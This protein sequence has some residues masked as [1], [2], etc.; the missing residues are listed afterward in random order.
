M[1]TCGSR[2]EARRLA[3]VVLGEKLAACVNILPG[4][5]S[6]YWWEG[7]LE[8]AP[9]WLLLIKTTAARA[10]QVETA[11]RSVHGYSVPEIIFLPVARGSAP[12]MKWLRAAVAGLALLLI[13]AAQADPLDD[14]I[15]LLGH[16]NEEVR[17]SAAERLTQIGGE[18]VEKQFRTMVASSNPESRQVGVVGL[19]QVSDSDEDLERVRALLQDES[20][21]VRWSAA[22][23]LGRSGYRQAADWLGGVAT[24]DTAESVREVAGEGAERLRTGIQW[25]RALD[26]ALRE[27]KTLSKP[28]LAY[29]FVPGSDYCVRME[30][31]VLRDKEIVN[32]A[33]EFVCARFSAVRQP[34][35]ARKFDVRGAPTLLVLDATGNEMTRIAGLV[36]APRLL[37]RLADARRGKLTL[38]DARRQAGRDP[39]DVAANWLVAESYLEDGREDLAEP[40]LRNV[41]A[42]D[43]DNRQGHTDDALFALGYALGKRGQHAASVVA[44]EKLVDRWPAFKDKDKALYCV[45]LSH[46]ALGHREAA[47]SALTR[48]VKELPDSPMARPAQ[49]ALDKLGANKE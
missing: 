40:F 32:A 26:A 27:A 35:I 1:V 11:I 48:L 31:G 23:A 42:A 7:K 9:E 28:V 22:L 44:L 45:G 39:R 24:N 13:P 33:Q 49:Q 38:R 34:E 19:L 6:H 47:R 14:W 21:T 25:Q 36:E 15:K 8:S 2:A 3:R 10:P 43:E 5:E 46:L 4:I 17:A 18:R 37:A 20:Q 12:Y 41:I 29:F 16:T 30:D